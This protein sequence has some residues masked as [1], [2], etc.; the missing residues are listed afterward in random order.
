M[1]DPFSRMQDPAKRAERYRRWRRNTLSWPRAE[2]SEFGLERAIPQG[3]AE[4]QT[5]SRANKKTR[6]V[7]VTALA[8]APSNWKAANLKQNRDHQVVRA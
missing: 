7:T 3:S 5:K 1:D 6:A 8:A 4:R 2:A